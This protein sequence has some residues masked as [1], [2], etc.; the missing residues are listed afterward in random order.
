MSAIGVSPM[1]HIDLPK[2]YHSEVTWGLGDSTC[3]RRKL[4]MCNELE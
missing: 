3:D 1:E 2:T 4:K